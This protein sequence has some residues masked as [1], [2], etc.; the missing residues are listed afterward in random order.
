[1]YGTFDPGTSPSIYLTPAAVSGLISALAWHPGMSLRVWCLA[2]QSLTML[3]NIPYAESG[4]SETSWSPDNVED[5][6]NS[7]HGM[8]K[9]IVEDPQFLPMLLRFLSGAGLSH[10]NN[11]DRGS[12]SIDNLLS[13][14]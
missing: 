8:A 7:L 10:T 3:A 14:G 11:S 4:S 5:L 1:M 2:F 9:F 6:E 12:V 13:F